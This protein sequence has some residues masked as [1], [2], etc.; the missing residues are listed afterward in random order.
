MKYLII[1][2]LFFL[3]VG[4]SKETDNEKLEKLIC[5]QI[6]SNLKVNLSEPIVIDPKVGIIESSDLKEK[7]NKIMTFVGNGKL[8]GAFDE[9]SKYTWLPSNEMD[10]AYDA[11]KKQLDLVR[12][13]FG[14]FI[15]YEFI[16]QEIIS[17]SLVKFTY[18][19][20]CENHA[21]PW[22]FV[23][24]KGQSKWTLNYFFWNDRIQEI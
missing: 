21:L 13:R 4:C 9:M 2:I 23:F 24:Y 11:T 14:T 19:A 10:S 17:E 5:D 16:K 15:G 18:I 20:K 1:P 6:Q 8:K 3:A 7:C 22:Y 12:N